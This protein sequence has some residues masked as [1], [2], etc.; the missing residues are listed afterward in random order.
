MSEFVSGPASAARRGV[1]IAPLLRPQEHGVYGLYAEPVLLGLALAPSLAGVAVALAGAAA[2]VAQQPAAL[3]L[4]DL[5]R[6]RRYPRTVVAARLASIGAA[7]AVTALVVAAFLAGL[8][9]ADGAIAA[10]WAPVLLALVPAGVQ[11]AADRA[12]KGKTGWAQTTGALALAALAPAIALAG[13]APPALAWSAW[14]WLGLRV[15]VSIPNV[16][17]R[18]RLARG[19]PA[20]LTPPRLAALPLP[21]GAVVGWAAGW[22]G[23]LPLAVAV[24]IAARS[25]WT[26]RR[27]APAVPAVRVGIAETVVGLAWVLALIVGLP[28]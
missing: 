8:W 4:A 23:P 21:L 19:R 12:L 2:I 14:G 7:V 10:W 5:R 22:I 28:R 27:A 11:F 9:P 1:P 6:G 13:G 17:A 18:L 25:L 3:A 20:R 26:L 24:A 16:R 15:L